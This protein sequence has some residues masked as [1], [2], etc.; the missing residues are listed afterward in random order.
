MSEP[1]TGPD[2]ELSAWTDPSSTYNAV[3]NSYATQFLDELDDKPFDRDLLQRF[4][5][6]VA[7]LASASTPVCDVG[8]GPGHVG[9]YVASL[10]LPAMGI[11]LS[12]GMVEVASVSF[13]GME[14]RQGDMTALHRTQVPLALSEMNRVL[15][16]DGELV[17]AVHG[18][19]GSLHADVM[20]GQPA[21]FDATLFGLGELSAFVTEAGFEVVEAHER[22]PYPRE[23][24]TPRL[25]VWARR[26]P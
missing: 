16:G 10:G 24:P 14:F 22:V 5:R 17:L 21:D 7:P 15:I 6:S 11:D 2:P 18:G 20:A 19:E 9:A 12:A 23:H 25:Y 13:P 4:A 3:A 1:V 8:C 26:L